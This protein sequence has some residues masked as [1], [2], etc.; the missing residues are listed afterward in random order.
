[1]APGVELADLNWLAI[2]AAVVV[3]MVLGFLWYS[4][5]LPTGRIWMRGTGLPMDMKLTGA[6]MARGMVLM[7]VG[8]FL[9]MFVLDHSFIAYRDAYRLD[10]ER[11]DG[12]TI[13][14]GLQGAFFTWL[15]FFVPVLWG[16][17]AWE[18]KPW[19]FFL[20]NAGYYLITLLIAGVLFVVIP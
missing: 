12:I 19:S 20:V 4:P 17:V 1:M 14:D 16:V 2:G 7:I 13:A 3:N 6:Q 5:K 9:V 8:A 10:G 18:N 11:L 15:G